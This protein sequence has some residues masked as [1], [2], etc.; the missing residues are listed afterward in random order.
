[1]DDAKGKMSKKNGVNRKPGDLSLIMQ[2]FYKKHCAIEH[3]RNKSKDIDR[4]QVERREKN[5]LDISQL[6]YKRK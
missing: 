1:M 6:Q 2:R 3:Q 5:G 4:N